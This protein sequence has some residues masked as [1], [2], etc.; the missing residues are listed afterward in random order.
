MPAPEPKLLPRPTPIPKFD[1]PKPEPIAGN[2]RKY[3][4]AL[5]VA[6]KAVN[7]TVSVNRWEKGCGGSGSMACLTGC[8][9]TLNY[10]VN[11][12]T[13]DIHGRCT[14]PDCVE[15]GGNYAVRP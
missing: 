6:M 12:D 15:W 8:G 5:T 10:G 2:A 9:G 13:G 7:F 3:F 14:T 11:P 4:D 1:P